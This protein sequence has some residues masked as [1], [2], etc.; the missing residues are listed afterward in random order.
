MDGTSEYQCADFFANS[1]PL[2]HSSRICRQVSLD[3]SHLHSLL[4]R[5]FEGK[6][7][8]KVIG[9]YSHQNST[10]AVSVESTI[11]RAWVRTFQRLS[12]PSRCRMTSQDNLISIPKILHVGDF[13]I[14]SKMRVLLDAIFNHDSRNVIELFS[15][16]LTEGRVVRQL[17][18][19]AEYQELDALFSGILVSWGIPLEFLLVPNGSNSNFQKEKII[20]FIDDSLQKVS[21]IISETECTEK[22]FEAMITYLEAI[23]LNIITNLNSSEHASA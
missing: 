9:A 19:R 7:K 1:N 15:S 14:E 13:F 10:I 6:Q 17:T 20:N 3:G 5:S 21:G 16:F 23:Y 8:L 2:L 12:L 18:N 11:L 22:R 4:S